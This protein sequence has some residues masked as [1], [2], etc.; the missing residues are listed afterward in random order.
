MRITRGNIKIRAII[1]VIKAPLKS[2][3]NPAHT[4]GA[5]NNILS[6]ACLV[7]LRLSISVEK[8]VG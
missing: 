7:N 8:K 5:R 6:K 4:I 2:K 1:E 3:I